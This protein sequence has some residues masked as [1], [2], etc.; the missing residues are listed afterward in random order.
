MAS[1]LLGIAG[2]NSLLFA[3]YVASKRVIS[4]F[5]DLSIQQIALAGGMAGA[6]NAILASPGGSIHSC[7][8]IPLNPSR[9]NPQSRCLKL[10]CK[11]STV[12]R[13][14]N[15]FGLSQGRCGENGV[16]QVVL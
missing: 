16:S 7:L 11:V 5:P 4:P 1:P 6:I 13:V 8:S 9:P 3:A 10:G 12:L 2:V 15:G 14:I